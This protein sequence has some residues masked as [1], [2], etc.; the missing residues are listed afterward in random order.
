[1]NPEPPPVTTG[2][3]RAIGGAFLLRRLGGTL[4]VLLLLSI[5]VFGLL[6]LAPGSV[7]Q[8]L[9]GTRPASPETVAAIRAQYHLDD[10]VAVQYLRWLGGALTG[11]LGTSIRTGIPV[12]EAIG[13]RLPLTLELTAY[14]TLLAV[15]AG[16]PLGILGAVRRGRAADRISVTA[17]VAGMSAP[18]FAVGL[19]LLMVFAVYNPWFPVYGP[20]EGLGGR[21][22][23][24]TLPAI[25]L[26]TGA[27]GLL[28][29]FTRAALIRQLDQDYVVFA[30]ARGL[31][32][33][34]VL[35]YALRNSLIP[36]LTAAGLIV[37]STLAGTVLVEVTFALPGLG[38]LLV[39]SVTF[40]D[41][42]VVQALALLLTLL[43]SVVNLLVDVGYTLADP[44]IRLGASR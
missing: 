26:A 24:L 13:S 44:R 14:G 32:S 23:H 38:S 30:R 15:L 12:T 40:K 3:R 8:T 5:G 11:D 18:P 31:P 4:V 10:P 43:I 9:L 7:E 27:A 36:I 6:Y 16:V 17:A 41:V 37:T 19:V 28:V 39:D 35:W 1:M 34:L 29:R 20:G 2:P 33:R 25:A 21:I 22:A 42:P